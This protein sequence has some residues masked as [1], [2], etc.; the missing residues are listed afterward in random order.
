MSGHLRPVRRESR[1]SR[2]AGR[3]WHD[4][5]NLDRINLIGLAAGLNFVVTLS[6]PTRNAA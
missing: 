2:P 5:E 1:V 6:S 3:S 4:L